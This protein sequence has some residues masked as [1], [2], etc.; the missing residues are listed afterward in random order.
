MS[1]VNKF[2]EVVITATIFFAVVIGGALLVKRFAVEMH[3]RYDCNGANCTW[4]YCAH[5]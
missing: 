5:K 3:E 4:E 2:A 1:K